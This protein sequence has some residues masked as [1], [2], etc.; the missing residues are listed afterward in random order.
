MW[1]SWSQPE[2]ERFVLGYLWAYH[3]GFGSGCVT[4]FDENAAQTSANVDTS[5]LQKCK[6]RE[7]E[8]SKDAG[9][10]ERVITEFPKSQY[11]SRAKK[12]LASTS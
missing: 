10:Y 1:L 2:R 7:L 6:L 4:F 5:P 12:S 8:Y 9:Y 3:S 11:A